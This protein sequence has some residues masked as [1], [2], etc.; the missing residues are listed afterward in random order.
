M[1]RGEGLARQLKLMNILETRQQ[2]AVPQ[3]AEELECTV[4]TVY[5]DLKVLENSGVPIYQERRGRA[6]RWRVV[7]GYKRRLSV[8]LSWPEMV[9]LLLG[10]DA[11]GVLAPAAESAVAK[12]AEAAPKEIGARALRLAGRI[13]GAAGPVRRHDAD[14]LRTMVD[15]I[16]RNETV[17]IRYRKPGAREAS[18]RNFDPYQLHVHAGAVYVLGFCHLRERVRTFLLDRV[19]EASHTGALFAAR[20]PFDAKEMLHGAFGP[21]QGEARRISLRFDPSVAHLAAESQ[22]HPTQKSQWTSDGALDLELRAPLCPALVRWVRGWGAQVQVLSPA[23][24]AQRVRSRAHESSL[25]R[26]EASISDST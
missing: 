21:W 14:L 10:R 25:L 2:I 16:E 20:A 8:T 23:A 6:A 19:A 26:K 3:V 12:V 9:A 11:A 15:A 1:S 24:L 22:M 18:A 5:R 17:H 4:R 7:D 13:S